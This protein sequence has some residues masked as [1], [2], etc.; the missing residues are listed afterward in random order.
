MG[1]DFNQ[2]IFGVLWLL[3]III[4]IFIKRADRLVYE[5]IHYIV[6]LMKLEDYATV[7]VKYVKDMGDEQGLAGPGRRLIAAQALLDFR[8]KLGLDVTHEQVE[9][10]IRAA[11]V[12]MKEEYGH[13]ELE[14]DGPDELDFDMDKIRT[15]TLSGINQNR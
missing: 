9:M 6:A 15:L 10:L 12:T 1:F 8:D 4:I 3:T 11:Y 14:K 2:L 13:P 5:K 7:V